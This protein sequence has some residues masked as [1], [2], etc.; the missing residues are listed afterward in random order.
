MYFLDALDAADRAF[1]QEVLAFI[2]EELDPALAAADDDQ[3]T[4]VAD[5]HRGNTWLKKLRPRR[6]H[7]GHWPASAGGAGLSPVQNYLL[8]YALGYAGA[9]APP[10]MGLIYV[11]PTIVRFGTPAQHETYL[12]PLLDGTE[13]WCQ[14]FSEPGAGSDLASL[15]TFAERRGDR[16][17]INGSKIWTTDAHYADRIFM[18]LRT[19]KEN[20]REAMSFLLVDMNAP[21]VS[22]RPIR[23]LTGDHEFNQVFFDNVEASTACRLGEEGQGWEIA[24]YLLEIERGS[25]VFGGRL[26]RRL[27][28]LIAR[29]RAAGRLTP[30]VAADFARLDRDLLAYES[31]EF[32][33]GTLGAGGALRAASANLIKIEWTELLQRIDDLALE[34]GDASM[35]HG[36]AGSVAEGGQPMAPA[37]ASCFNNLAATIY[38]GSNEIQRNL[39]MRVLRQVWG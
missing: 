30:R 29:I 27:E 15:S 5:H 9:P 17:I 33:M 37:L 24:R 11:G 19:A 35:L 13:E 38:G 4:F 22:V 2:E 10:P 6:W 31:M 1:H 21:G 12:P 34:T 7:A 20:T 39:V 8:L 23:M 18:L 16:Y 25:F 36:P 28:R 26:R 32:R 14:G 3:R